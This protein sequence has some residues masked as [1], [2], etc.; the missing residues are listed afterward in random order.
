MQFRGAAAE[1][2]NPQYLDLSP[3]PAIV[4]PIFERVVLP[5]GRV[6]RQAVLVVVLVGCVELPV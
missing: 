5:A 1:G 6:V 4:E 3:T 2:F